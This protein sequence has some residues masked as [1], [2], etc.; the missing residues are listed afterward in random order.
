MVPP[1]D[2]TAGVAITPTIA[3]VG[4]GFSGTA[5]ACR[6]LSR[7]P[8]S[9]VRIA[10]IER[11]GRFGPGLAYA[12][13]FPGALLNV[14][15]GRMSLDEARPADFLEF[16]IAQDV[17]ATA[18]AFLPRALYGHYLEARL[19]S[20]ARTAAP[21]A[22]LERITG[23]VVGMTR[24]ATAGRWHIA[25]SDG[26]GVVVDATVLA[27]GHFPPASFAALQ[28]LVGTGSLVDDPWRPASAAATTRPRGRVLLVGTGLTMADV[29]CD[30]EA[31][32]DR[33]LEL[34]A[35]SRRGLLSR[36]RVDADARG[37]AGVVHG[38]ALQA[39]RSARSAVATVRDI[40]DE[41][42]AAGI[43]W[44]ETLQALRDDVP[45]LWRL[46]D[47]G[48]RRRLLRHVQPWWDAHRHLLPPAV[49]RR[50][51]ALR[52]DGR[53]EVRAARIVAAS[54]ADGRMTVGLRPRGRTDVEWQVFDR[55]V[56]CSGPE[57]DVRRIGDP[58]VRSLLADGNIVPDPAGVGIA[59][60][61]IGRPLGADGKVAEDL[62]YLGPW[63][64]GRDFEATAVHELRR[65]A[66]ALAGTLRNSLS[67]GR[68]L[69][70]RR[71][72]A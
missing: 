7:P 37:G 57:T 42:M 47:T 19:A 16:A 8:P 50:L 62:H 72:S 49:G 6:L 68:D 56:N 65:H 29:A 44:R 38:A 39:V 69:G 22:S 9:G 2:P 66:S 32:G 48:E 21:G 43:D 58:L 40:V 64:R 1:Y 14:P 24:D 34:V 27:L 4:A 15:A 10:L 28:P 53:L 36:P 46:L 54:R 63:L 59:V 55:V 11:A 23:E 45:V 20:A 12:G 31:N 17:P 3:I 33:G 61:A 70:G 5:L 51:E 67:R 18:A 30:L 41:A 25:L 35:V 52:R 26:R 71:R 13:Q 60:D